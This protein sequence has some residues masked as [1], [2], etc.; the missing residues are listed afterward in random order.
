MHPTF[1][2]VLFTIDKTQKQP[3][4]PPMDKWTQ[5]VE[6][7]SA[8]T[9]KEILPFATTLMELEDIMLTQVSQ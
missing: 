2:A 4:C 3:K 8:V 6:Y 5:K 7:Y 9:K 1:T